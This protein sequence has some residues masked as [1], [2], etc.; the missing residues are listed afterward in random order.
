MTDKMWV[1]LERKFE[2]NDETYDSTEGGNCIIAYKTEKEAD[3]AC[4][5]MMVESIRKG[6]TYMY[7]GCGSVFYRDPALYAVLEKYGVDYDSLY[8][9][10][11]CEEL[12]EKLMTAPEEDL[13]V[14]VDLLVYPLYFVQDV[15]VK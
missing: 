5:R 12:F 7:A 4:E 13:V 10:D 11:A 2:Y 6:V 9:Y 1:V 15:E 14:V 3:N 8:R